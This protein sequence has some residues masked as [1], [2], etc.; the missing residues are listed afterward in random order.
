MTAPSNNL[1]VCPFEQLAIPLE[2]SGRLGTNRAD[3]EDLQIDVHDDVGAV[4]IY[5]DEYKDS[6]GTQRIYR[7]EAER[8]MLWSLVT[9]NKPLSSL[10]R[11]DVS[12]YVSFLANPQPT[13]VWCGPRKQRNS[14]DW[15]PF[16]SG[17]QE[18]AVMT[19]LAALSSMFNW[20]ADAGYLR[21]NP[22]GLIR[23]KKKKEALLEQDSIMERHLDQDMWQAVLQTVDQWSCLDEKD[24]AFKERG[25]FILYLLYLLAPR[26]GELESHRMNSFSEVRGHW[27]WR[28]VGKGQKVAKVPV[29]DDMISALV[30]YR[31]FLDLPAA[32]SNSDTTPL[33]LSLSDMRHIRG[34]A[35]PSK[36]AKSAFSRGCT[37]VSARQLNR[38]LKEIFEKAALSLPASMSHK[39]DKLRAASAHWGR[40]T[41]ITA[42]VDAGVDARYTQ[43]N[44]RHSDART[45][46]LY[47]HEE[48][49]RWHEEAQKLRMPPTANEKSQN[50]G[51]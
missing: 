46:G 51:V 50:N 41:S 32:P 44:A 20:L 17:L 40:H 7:R 8:L 2:L 43:K 3:A 13:E 6:P 21:G 10:N 45:T 15:R 37:P 23:Q 1:Q 25:R 9:K 39:A 48:D 18:D 42:M 49:E 16:V 19:A 34:G 29:P 38:I 33:V 11:S 27:W 4:N 30:R 14:L 47:T 22:L 36:L 31:K 35:F 24:L 12:E 26:A 5:L 28:V